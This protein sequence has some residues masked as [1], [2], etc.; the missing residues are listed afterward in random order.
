M[1]SVLCGCIA[2]AE[3]FVNQCLE[4]L[5]SYW[6]SLGSK[7]PTWRS[8]NLEFHFYSVFPMTFNIRHLSQASCHFSRPHNLI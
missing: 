7:G 1:L 2:H 6:G 4:F 5:G 8:S 3:V